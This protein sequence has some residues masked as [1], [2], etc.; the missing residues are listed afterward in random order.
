MSFRCGFCCELAPNGT[1]KTMI[2]TKLREKVEG[3]PG[4]DRGSEIVQELPQCE[5]CLSLFDGPEVLRSA[6]EK[7]LGAD[8]IGTWRD[9]QPN[10]V[11]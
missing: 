7:S 10:T 5:R 11:S 6:M 9:L 3:H 4:G 8:R 2:P 1:R